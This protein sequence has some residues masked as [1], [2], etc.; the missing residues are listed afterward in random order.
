MKVT[1]IHELMNAVTQEVLGADAVL[2]EDLSNVVDIGTQIVDANAVD[3]YVKSLVDRIG[4]VIFVNR[5]YSGNV[6]SIMMDSFEFGAIT[7]KISADLPQATENSSWELE[8]GQ[9]YD[10]N[11]YYK[12]S[13]SAKFFSSKVTFEVPMSFTERQV[14]SAFANA[15]ELNAFVTMLYNAVERTITV[16]IDSLIMSTINSMTAQTLHAEYGTAAFGSKSTVKAVNLLKLYNDKFSKT[17]T[18]ASCIT[19]PDFIKFASMQMGLYADRLGK[20]STLFNIGHKDRFTPS[21]DLHVVML[22]DFKAAANSYLQSDTFHNEFTALPSAETVPY[23]QG[24]GE[25]YA[26]DSVSKIHVQVTDPANATKTVTV[27]CGGILAVMFDREAVGVSNLDRRVTTQYNPRGEFYTN[28]YKFEAGYYNDMNE[29]F[30]VFF[31]ADAA[32]GA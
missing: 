30:V 11:I 26:F 3:H 14:K 22:T 24:S 1:Q 27:E 28:F 21:S 29:N 18:A 9:S 19:D 13:V 6:P 16:K 5:A 7:Q 8:N 2:K 20:L 32:T 12:P 17:L 15:A 23:W 10:P 25:E 4:K 31:V